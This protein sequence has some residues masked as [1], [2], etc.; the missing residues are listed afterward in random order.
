MSGYK[1]FARF[2]DLLTSNISYPARALYFDGIIRK[3]G[4]KRGLLLDLACGTGTLSAEFAALGY[5][6]VAVDGSPDMLSFACAKYASDEDSG[7]IAGGM[8]FL[9]QDM[10]R[11]D[12]FGT[13]GAAVC[14]LDGLNHLKSAADFER[15]LKRVALFCEPGGLFVFDLNTPHKHRN[16]LGNNAFVYDFEEVFCVWR[17]VFT[18]RDLR[19]DVRLDFFEKQ[20]KNAYIKYGE[21]FSETA[22]PIEVTDKML[23]DCG[24]KILAK[25]GN[26]THEDYKDGDE[27]IIYA[28]KRV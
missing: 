2:Y 3:Y 22:Y 5:D 26:Y 8:Q 15:A 4:G 28:V 10:T 20:E 23:T 1:S 6:V 13:V 19:V 7:G 9:C 25:F 14:A 11:L 27:K 12:L 18:E 17:N 21:S 24:F 16:V